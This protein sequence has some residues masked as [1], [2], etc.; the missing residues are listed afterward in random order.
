M[1]IKNLSV[2]AQTIVENLIVVALIAIIAV[3]VYKLVKNWTQKD[4]PKPAVKSHKIM[5]A[6]SKELCTFMMKQC[7]MRFQEEK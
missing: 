6:P 3:G 2:K 5:D 7:Q 1:I 4:T